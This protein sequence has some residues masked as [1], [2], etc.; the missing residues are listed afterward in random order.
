M[1]DDFSELE[2]N[3]SCYT[4]NSTTSIYAYR[5]NIRS[6]YTQIGGKWFKS[7]QT[8]YT[9]VPTNSVCY[10]YS[11]ITELSSNAVYYPFLVAIAFSLAVFV[12]MFAF[13]VFWDNL[14]RWRI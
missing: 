8:S 10:S 5:S 3:A 13:K 11:D 1:T 4:I 7:A 14:V 12:F 9:S 6:S 2:T